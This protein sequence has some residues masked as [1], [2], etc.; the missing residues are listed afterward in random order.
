[1]IEIIVFRLRLLLK[2]KL[3]WAVLVAALLYVPFSLFLAFSSYVRP[4]K[5]YWDLT[6]GFSFVAA[7]L[8]GS[9]LG[10]HLFADEQQRKTLSFVLTLKS[11]RAEWLNG[12]FFGL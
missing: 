6:T 4:D 2:Q 5:I 12:N 10:S 8:L 1:M 11:S 7:V 9:Y 3:G